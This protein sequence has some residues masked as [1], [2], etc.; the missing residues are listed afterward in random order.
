MAPAEDE[1][2]CFTDE[3]QV[4]QIKSKNRKNGLGSLLALLLSAGEILRGLGSKKLV[5]YCNVQ[6]PLLSYI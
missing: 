1:R 2:Y 4:A 3:G 5:E 6:N